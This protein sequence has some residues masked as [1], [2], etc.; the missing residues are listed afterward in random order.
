MGVGPQGHNVPVHG[1]HPGEQGQE[2]DE[3]EAAQREP[4]DAERQAQVTA[5]PHLP[6]TILFPNFRSQTAIYSFLQSL[7]ALFLIQPKVITSTFA[8]F[9]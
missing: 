7:P 6:N 4:R 9:A 8:T 5:V 3:G 2:V 1:R